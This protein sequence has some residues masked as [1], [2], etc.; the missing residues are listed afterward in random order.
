MHEHPVPLMKII[1]DLN[2][3]ILYYPKTEDEI[4]V[5]HAE[6]MRP[7]LAF[8]GFYGAFVPERISLI[9]LTELSYLEQMTGELRRERLETFFRHHPKAVIITRSFSFPDLMMELARLHGVPV[10]LSP[11]NTT[12]MAAQL[13]AK[14][15]LELAP[16]V[17]EYGVL[18]EIYGEGVLLTGD[19][20]VGKSETALELIK[21]GH[22]LIA[23]DAVEIRRVSNQTLVG[24]APD[25][26][27]HFME[28]RGVGIVNVSR[29]FGVGAVKN[30]AGINFIIRL[31]SYSPKKAYDR[32]GLNREYSSILGITVPTITIPVQ[33]GRN[34]AVIIEVA[35]MNYRQR[36]M[37]H[38]AGAELLHQLGLENDISGRDG[39][40]GGSGGGPD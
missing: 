22:R 7:G 18:M 26:I 10:I 15:S 31:E 8:S 20:G 1:Q 35:T 38:D 12:H 33:T 30:T 13:N 14:L 23:D 37:G 36:M 40:P 25:N 27:R 17:T 2:L 5:S 28:L 9:G 29:L 32:L 3:K 11:E 6:L 34:L 39:E 21:R 16:R 19:S 24:S 4:L